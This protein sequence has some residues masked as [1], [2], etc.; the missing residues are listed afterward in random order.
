MKSKNTDRKCKY[1]DIIISYIP[2]KIRCLDCHKKFLDNAM[3]SHKIFI[4]FN[5]SVLN[6]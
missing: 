1:C 4:S 6:E 5:N 3:I 2:R